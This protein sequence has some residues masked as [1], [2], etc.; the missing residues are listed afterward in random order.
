M[1][2]PH[3][4]KKSFPLFLSKEHADMVYLDNA[5]TTQKPSS[6]LETVDHYYRHDNANPR[7]G[8]STMS[9]N[10]E[11]LFEDARSTVKQ[12]IGAA[13]SD[14]IVF[15]KNATEALNL[16]AFGW[17][18]KHL[19]KKDTVIISVM[20]HHSHMLPWRMA[21]N[22]AGAHVKYVPFDTLGMVDLGA[23]E[24][25]LKNGAKMVA[26]TDVSNVFGTKQELDTII[27]LTHQYGAI[28]SV[29]GAQAVA[30]GAV[31]VQK[32]GADF[33]AFSGHKMYA[34]MGVGVLYA[35][36][37]LLDTMDPLLYGGSMIEQVTQDN[38]TWS[39]P[40]HRFEGGTQDVAA[41]LGLEAAIRYLGQFSWSDIAEHENNL[42]RYARAGLETTPGIILYANNK[43]KTS[44][45]SFNLSGVH[46]HDLNHIFDQQGVVVRSGHHC[47]QPL[48]ESLGITGTLRLSVG[49][50][51]SVE[52]ID[53]ALKSVNQASRIFAHGK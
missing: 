23:L 53:R 8:V 14:E 22:S 44:L 13:S 19:T 32:L 12:F 6:V 11:K 18:T 51:N 46:P 39:S 33:Y 48:M 25:L 50:Y 36:K 42:I 17:G 40:P 28:V 30:H 34:P 21:A 3:I 1:I 24:K 45:I 2:K 41:V 43:A 47:S 10:A 15:T 49:L 4:I 29:D 37:D 20:E 27:A 5:A 31:N 26:V 16:A 7:R 38:A 9:Y 35:K 52:D